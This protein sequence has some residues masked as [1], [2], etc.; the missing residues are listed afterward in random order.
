[1]GLEM[2]PISDLT[3]GFRDA[4]NYLRRENKEMFN[5]IF[6][7]T[8]ELEEL[9]KP[10]KYFLIGEKGTGKTAYAVFLSNME[11][12]NIAATLRYIRE[13]EYSKFV[14]MKQA[15]HL[16][17]SDYMHVWKIIIYLLLSEQI[18]Q[19][20]KIN[21]VSK[22]FGAFSKLLD[23]IDEFYHKA[24][25]PEIVQAIKFAE[26]AEI[27][28]D[29]ITQFANV[30]AK[31]K[32]STVFT[33][34]Q[35][36]VNLLYIQKKFEDALSSLK[37]QKNHIV[38]IDG[39]DIRPSFI[40]YRDYLE[41]VKG[42]AN[43]VWSLNNDFFANIKDSPGRMRVVLLMR[44]D[45]FY[46]VGLQNQNNKI[47]DNSV[48]LDWITT[49][50]EFRY[51][52]LFALFDKLLSFQQ[53]N[54]LPEGTAWDHY[55]PFDPPDLYN[56]KSDRPTS[57]VS[58]LRYSLYRPRDI[59][60]MLEILQEN[61]IKQR[62]HKKAVFRDIDFADPSFKRNYSDYLLGEVKDQLLFYYTPDDYEMFLKFFQYLN[63]KIEFG[64]D[65]YVKA[66]K[67]FKKFLKKNKSSPTFAKSADTFLQFLYD[68]NILCF[69][70]EAYD[71]SKFFGWCFRDRSPSNIAPKVR[72]HVRYRIHFGLRKAIDVG[73]KLDISYD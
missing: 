53:D 20:E 56:V 30:G 72:T 34:N 28:A 29:I 14:S 48:V 62:R 10:G 66:F 36:Q 31:E 21:L 7:R 1:M 67:S 15:K 41:C 25:S 32:Y 60:T 65:E 68:L 5:Q 58:F 16:S 69:I 55:F 4:E 12:K 3:F 18:R 8:T 6:L 13:T 27:S 33:E 23:A 17:L 63:G 42:L 54:E 24:F 64:Y 70:A 52:K 49:Y 73:K 71:N 45:I 19:K 47:R 50:E 38:F 40:E 44:P 46:S 35:Y 11:Y 9:C 22:K 39:I 59:L 57:F 43:A 51:S 2:K 26:D 37:L 61:F